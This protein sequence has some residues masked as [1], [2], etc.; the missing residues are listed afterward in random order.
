MAITPQK[1]RGV[2]LNLGLRYRTS[3]GY[4]GSGYSASKGGH[5]IGD[6]PHVR[7]DYIGA[8]RDHMPSSVRLATLRDKLKGLGFYVKLEGRNFYCSVCVYDDPVSDEGPTTYQVMAD[9]REET[10]ASLNASLNGNKVQIKDAVSE[11]ARRRKDLLEKK[12]KVEKW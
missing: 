3:D 5:N 2:I 1:M 8:G 11:L 4:G 7:I 12:R 10:L 9:A 6:K